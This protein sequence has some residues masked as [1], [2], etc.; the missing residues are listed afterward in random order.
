[1]RR[2]AYGAGLGGRQRERGDLRRG[3][4]SNEAFES[5]TPF[6]LESTDVLTNSGSADR[7][8]E[9]AAA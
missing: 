8:Q 9:R 5:V 1:M 7:L 2:A 3:R 6:S 4:D